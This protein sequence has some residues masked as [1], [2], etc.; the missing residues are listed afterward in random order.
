MILGMGGCE[1]DVS[2]AAGP[3]QV[4]ATYEQKPAQW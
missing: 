4:E 3:S 1:A 2:D